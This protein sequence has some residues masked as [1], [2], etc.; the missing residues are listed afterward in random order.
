[1][2]DVIIL[3][4]VIALHPDTLIL[5]RMVMDA[6]VQTET[7]RACIASAELEVPRKPLTASITNGAFIG[8][9]VASFAG[10]Y[11][12]STQN[13]PP[14]KPGT[15]LATYGLVGAVLGGTL[16]AMFGE[17]EDRWQPLR[18][19]HGPTLSMDELEASCRSWHPPA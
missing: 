1:M 9:I 4:T 14:P 2:G 16:G 8:A 5:Q 17:R 18:V 19:I 10:I 12:T 13:S 15:L 7:P 3:G 11:T 6:A